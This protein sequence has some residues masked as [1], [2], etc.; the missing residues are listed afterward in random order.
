M[1]SAAR[2]CCRASLRRTSSRENGDDGS[3]VGSIVGE[4]ELLGVGCGRGLSDRSWDFIHQLP[5]NQP[6]APATGIS[7]STTRSFPNQPD[8]GLTLELGAGVA[9][10]IG[11]GGG[12][13]AIVASVAE[14]GS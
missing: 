2:R 12:A 5:A 9:G 7:T 1:F 10:T 14:D 6:I 4:T 3:G 8:D 13:T 11:A